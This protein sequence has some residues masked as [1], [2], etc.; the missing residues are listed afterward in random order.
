MEPENAMGHR[1]LDRQQR[2]S[3]R[4]CIRNSLQDETYRRALTSPDTTISEHQPTSY[5]LASLQ[6]FLR[7]E[8][9]VEFNALPNIDMFTFENRSNGFVSIGSAEKKQVRIGKVQESVSDDSTAY[10]YLGGEGTNKM[11]FVEGNIDVRSSS[12]LAFLSE[13]ELEEP[14]IHLSLDNCI[15]AETEQ[16]R[17]RAFDIYVFLCSNT[18]TTVEPYGS[19]LHDL[20]M[21]CTWMGQKIVDPTVKPLSSRAKAALG[22]RSLKINVANRIV[23]Q[24]IIKPNNRANI[25]KDQ[26]DLDDTSGSSDS[27]DTWDNPDAPDISDDLDNIDSSEDSESSDN[28]LNEELTSHNINSFERP[29][30]KA[31]LGDAMSRNQ[32]QY[33]QMGKDMKL[34]KNELATAQRDDGSKA[35][36]QLTICEQLIKANVWNKTFRKSTLRK[37]NLKLITTLYCKRSITPEDNLRRS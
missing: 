23:R 11:F 32:R 3:R 20:R 7:K 36:L 17:F 27:S 22:R 30:K 4:S 35:K 12:G 33:V 18:E 21:A 34:L 25:A 10:L 31:R 2:Q 8:C 5:D 28:E 1:R 9:P 6:E 37:T 13:V 15:K 26:E 29:A 14:F 16:R 19:F 24:P